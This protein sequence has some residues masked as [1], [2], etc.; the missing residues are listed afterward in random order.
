[1]RRM[2][3][4]GGKARGTYGGLIAFFTGRE[5]GNGGILGW[6]EGRRRKKWMEVGEVEWFWLSGRT[7][8]PGWSAA[9]NLCDRS[10]GGFER[11]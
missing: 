4:E 6:G 2:S 3:E 11:G 10:F 7:E 5:R 8:E 9:G 1:M